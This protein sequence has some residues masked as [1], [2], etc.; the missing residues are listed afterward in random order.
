MITADHCRGF[1]ALLWRTA[2]AT[3]TAPAGRRQDKEEETRSSIRPQFTDELVTGALISWPS[4]HAMAEAA[5]ARCRARRRPPWPKELRRRAWIAGE[6]PEC[7]E[8]VWVSAL[9]SGGS[10]VTSIRHQN[11]RC[12]R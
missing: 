7:F 9:V 1:A 12:H 2:R 4:R 8:Y 3:E 11:R 10:R 5:T 6:R